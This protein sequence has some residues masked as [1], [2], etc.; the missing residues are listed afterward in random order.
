[1]QSREEWSLL[2][3]RRVGTAAGGVVFAGSNTSRCSRGRRGLYW[4]QE[5]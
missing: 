1:M 5:E 2:A 4:Q 3:A